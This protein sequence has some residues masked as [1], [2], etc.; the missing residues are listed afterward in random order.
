MVDLHCRFACVRWRGTKP[1]A[2]KAVNVR[3]QTARL[4]YLSV[5]KR[6]AA[7]SPQDNGIMYTTC[8]RDRFSAACKEGLHA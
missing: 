7:M 6:E 1:A 2:A 5:A 4:R 3:D 8:W